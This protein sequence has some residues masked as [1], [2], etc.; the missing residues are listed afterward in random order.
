MKKEKQIINELLKEFEDYL[1]S[2]NRSQFTLRQYK[3][4]WK[5]FKDYSASRNI[6][7]Y[8]RTVGDQFI[9]S[10]LGNYTYAAL[11]QMQRR[12]VNTIDALFIFQEEGILN[13]GPAPL[14]RKP[15]RKFEGEIG[16]AMEAF[17]N[18]KKIVFNL[19]KTSLRAHHQFLHEF[20]L[21]LNDK[22]IKK[23]LEI[24][25]IYIF[26][27]IKS[28]P[29]KTLA[30][31]HSKLGVI[32]SFLRYA[33]EEQ[34][35]IADYASIIQRDNYKEQPKVPSV[36]SE[37]E[38][39][40]LLQSVERSNPSGK[41]DYVIILLAAKLGM[42]A[43]D[44]AGLQFENIDWDQRFIHFTQFKTNKE[45][46]LP[47][48]PEVGNAI[49]D[50]LKYGRPESNHPYCFLQLIGPYKAISAGDVGRI[51]QSQMQRANINTK[52]RRH[53]PHALRHSFATNML[54]N[55]TSL[56]VISEV[57]G[58]TSTESTM[59]YLRVSKDQLKQCALEVPMVAVS[60]YNQKG[61]FKS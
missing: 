10:Q 11:N 36:F 47:L 37:E 27:F 34:L 52:N 6:K 53:G 55:E 5:K 22:E 4:I 12:L 7:Y 13:M 3:Y 25:Q 49:I 2:L 28:L 51:V 24:S 41:R 32:K 15:P 42:R 20:L 58:H 9:K 33:F 48:L 18:Y 54:Q 60:F 17:I 61:G 14:K 35:I 44:I 21:F 46:V 59:Y 50:Y 38:I 26:S 30:V 1:I 19:A 57:L 31:N 45:L 43:G 40:C 56:P 39:K 16:L 29:A 23:M 8:D